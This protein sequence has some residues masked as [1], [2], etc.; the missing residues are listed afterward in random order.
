LKGLTDQALGEYQKAT[1]LND[2]PLPLA[3]LGHL[4]GKIGRRKEALQILDQLRELRDSSKDRYV[5]PY[6]LALVHL[7]LDQKDEAMQFLKETYEDRDGYNIMFIRIEPLLDPL[8]G[9]PRFE[10]LA[11]K[12]L[13]SR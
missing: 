10:A 3:L 1:A 12:V 7:G 8:R 13:P 6:N 9:D 11:E 2:D 4:C 5:S